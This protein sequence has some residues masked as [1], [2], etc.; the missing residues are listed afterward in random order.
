MPTIDRKDLDKHLKSAP[1]HKSSSKD[2]RHSKGSRGLPDGYLKDGYFNDKGYLREELITVQAREIALAFERQQMKVTALR[3]FFNKIKLITRKFSF[4]QDYD[5]EKA[6]PEILELE[7]YA[8][9]TA[10]RGVMPH[11]FVE[12]ITRNVERAKVNQKA[13]CDGFAKHCEYVVAY[14]PRQK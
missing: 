5:F 8:A 4:Q 12:F 13:F 9:Y 6:L 2:S 11:M 7:P 1:S 14:F 3:K 10:N